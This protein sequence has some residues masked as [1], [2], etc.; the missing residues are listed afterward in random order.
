[1]AIKTEHSGAK[2][3]GG[4]WGRRALAKE[5]SNIIRRRGGIEAIRRE[6]AL[7][8]GDDEAI[9]KSLNERYPVI[10]AYLA[11]ND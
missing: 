6:A 8:A 9:R 1:M 4:Y 2:N 5:V 7:I 10:T 11:K 3:G